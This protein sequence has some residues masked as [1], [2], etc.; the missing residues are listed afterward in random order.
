MHRAF[1]LSC[2]LIFS[3]GCYGPDR[4]PGDDPTRSDEG[5]RG[6]KPESNPYETVDPKG[7]SG[8]GTTDTNEAAKDDRGTLD[9]TSDETLA[10]SREP[11]R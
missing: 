4:E 2:L 11:A 9:G 1:L 10:P 6:G 7:I 3:A 5:P 8:G